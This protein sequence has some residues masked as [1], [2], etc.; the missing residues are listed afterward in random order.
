LSVY[1][2]FADGP[3]SYLFESVEGGETWGRHS[4]IGLPAKRTYGFRG[5]RLEVREHGALVESR[6]VEDP[7]AEVERLRQ[8]F[9]VPQL[10]G[11]PAFTGGLVGYFGFECTG[12][13]EPRLRDNPL[14]DAL[15][16]PDAVL[17]LSEEVAVFDNL[18]GK[19]YL[20]VHADPSEPRAHARA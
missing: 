7:L 19:L 16:T 11:L 5:D 1:L 15:G 4:I 18:A 8:S 6:Q 13:T 3:G 12:W 14:L 9:R 20:V 10:P 2:K 17:L